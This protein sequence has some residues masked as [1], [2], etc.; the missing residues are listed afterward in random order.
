MC[1]ARRRARRW[2]ARG[3]AEQIGRAVEADPIAAPP[4]E[5]LAEPAIEQ[6][7]RLSWSWGW[8][9]ELGAVRSAGPSPAPA[10][11][12]PPA[13]DAAWR[14]REGLA[15]RA[16]GSMGERQAIGR[17]RALS[18][19]AYCAARLSIEA[20]GGHAGEAAVRRRLVEMGHAASRGSV[21]RRQREFEHVTAELADEVVSAGLGAITAVESVGSPTSPILMPWVGSK[22]DLVARLAEALPGAPE[23][24]CEAMVG[25]GALFLHLAAAGRV[26]EA[27]LSDADADVALVW[28]WVK[29]APRAVHGHALWWQGQADEAAYYRARD[30]LNGG[31]LSGVERAGAALYLMWGAYNGLWRRNRDGKLNS[32]VGRRRG[33]V[34]RIELTLDGILRI[35]ELLEVATVR[36]GDAADVIESLGAG[37]VAYLDPPYWTT[38]LASGGSFTGYDGRGFSAGSLVRMVAALRGLAARGGAG[39]LSNASVAPVLA[40]CEGAE[41]RW[42]VARRKVSCAGPGQ[43][44]EVIARWHGGVA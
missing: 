28:W 5:L 19:E 41:V 23:Q 22:R 14:A 20:E 2:A 39:L 10:I 4:W 34:A 30:V 26:R 18:L 29:H 35:A 13:F 38:E 27:V 36:C 25:S 21:I 32:P 31:V 6:T 17:P 12:G 11:V 24:F 42:L 44:L 37:W 3:Q 7:T 15:L 43:A 1:L 9:R 33:A 40:L 8:R 16:D